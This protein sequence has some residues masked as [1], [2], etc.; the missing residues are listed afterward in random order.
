M[1]R[2]EKKKKESTHFHVLI[3]MRFNLKMTMNFV[4][5]I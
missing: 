5:L 4:I 1:K 2:K 3:Y